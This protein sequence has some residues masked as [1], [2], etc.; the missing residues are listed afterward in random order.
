MGD[1]RLPAHQVCVPV[2]LLRQDGLPV[3]TGPHSAQEQ[4]W[5]EQG[6][7]PLFGL[8][9][10]QSGQRGQDGCRMGLPQVVVQAKQ[11]LK[12]ATAV[13]AT[14]FKL[15]EALRVFG[16]P[17]GTWTGGRTRWNRARFGL[18]KSQCSISVERTDNKLGNTG[19]L[20]MASL[21]NDSATLNEEVY[22]QPLLHPLSQALKLKQMVVTAI[23]L[24]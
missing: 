15:V 20:K 11:P 3:R 24:R 7:Q 8:P 1:P 4:G 21:R 22:S 9:R 19:S 10:V 2:R 16:L 17:I 18:E 5:V 6:Q 14:R 23:E 13:N 12:D